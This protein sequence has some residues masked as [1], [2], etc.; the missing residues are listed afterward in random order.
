MVRLSD[1]IGPDGRFRS[2]EERVKK[3]EHK[4][5]GVVKKETPLPSVSTPVSKK[6]ELPIASGQEEAGKL[7]QDAVLWV[8]KKFQEAETGAVIDVSGGIE[9]SERIVKVLMNEGEGLL[10]F[11]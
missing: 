8:K 11:A 6:S 7:Y 2:P 3:P 9:I 10:T 4:E 1:V 5:E